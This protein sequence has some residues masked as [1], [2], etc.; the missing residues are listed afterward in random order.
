MDNRKK[1]IIAAIVILAIVIVAIIWIIVA[2]RQEG[3]GGEPTTTVT[4]DPDTGDEIVNV[5]GK[6]PENAPLEDTIMLLGGSQ[7]ID[8]T[9]INNTQYQFF[10]AQLEHFAEE[11]DEKINTIKLLPESIELLDSTPSGVP[12]LYGVQVKTVTTENLE[13]TYNST[14]R[15]IGLDKIQLIINDTNGN[16]LFDSGVVPGFQEEGFDEGSE[17]DH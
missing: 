13:A 16:A 9:S 10:T 8:K 6:T 5:E 1:L 7:F 4:I 2:S 11:T 14:L 15:L 12:F 17:H 3:D